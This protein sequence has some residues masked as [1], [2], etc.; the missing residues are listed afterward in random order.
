M[1]WDKEEIKKRTYTIRAE[2]DEPIFVLRAQDKSAPK[3]IALWIAANI[4]T[5]PDHKLIEAMRIAIEMRQWNKRKNA[6]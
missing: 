4:E 3:T 5:A 2:H 1:N 6:D